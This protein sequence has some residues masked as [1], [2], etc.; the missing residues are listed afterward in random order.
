MLTA[1][2]L[3]TVTSQNKIWFT[4][5]TVSRSIGIIITTCNTW[6]RYFNITE[7]FNSIFSICYSPGRG[8]ITSCQI[9]KIVNMFGTP[10]SKDAIDK[11]MTVTTFV[12]FLE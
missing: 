11:F 4:S 9:T 10:A 12:I 5:P 3:I 1:D 6:V 2:K 8:Y 7:Y